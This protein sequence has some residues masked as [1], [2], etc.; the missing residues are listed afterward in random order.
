[1]MLLPGHSPGQFRIRLADR[2][3]LKSPIPRIR[4]SLIPQIVTLRLRERL[5][6]PIQRQEKSS[7]WEQP[8]RSPGRRSLPLTMSRLSI[9]LI[10]EPISRFLV[11]NLYPQ[12]MELITGLSP[13]PLARMW[14]LALAMLALSRLMQEYLV[15]LRL[16]EYWRLLRRW[17]PISGR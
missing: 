10:M 3:G 15:L 2:Q 17:V 1:M 13:M 5:I 12:L 7:E 6:S 16:R 9:R 8:R 11:P 14:R 4:P